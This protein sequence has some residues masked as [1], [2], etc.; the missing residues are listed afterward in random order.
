MTFRVLKFGHVTYFVHPKI[1]TDLASTMSEQIE[2]PATQIC[3]PK[4][5]RLYAR[6][7][8]SKEKIAI[9][10]DPLPVEL[11]THDT[12]SISSNLADFLPNAP[13]GTGGSTRLLSRSFT[14]RT[15]S[16]ISQVLGLPVEGSA[17]VVPN[18]PGTVEL[19]YSPE[20]PSF[21]RQLNDVPGP[22]SLA[23][24]CRS[25]ADFDPPSTD[26]IDASFSSRINVG[27]SDLSILMLRFETMWI[28]LIE[29]RRVSV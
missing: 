6:H 22:T 18:G 11:I 21:T 2:M 17:V 28:E 1:F 15:R 16:A 10:S 26:A 12:V 29:R 27:S 14:E 3:A 23:V 8:S 5:K 4:Q 24:F 19:G 25:L 9:Y 7:F 20:G 13:A